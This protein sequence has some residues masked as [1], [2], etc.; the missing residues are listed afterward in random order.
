MKLND[1]IK[2][3]VAVTITAALTFSLTVSINNTNNTTIINNYQ[4][5]TKK[6]EQQDQK[7]NT[8]QKVS[9]DIQGN[10][11]QVES[12][13]NKTLTISKEILRQVD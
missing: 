1:L 11:S 3:A 4:E 12:N 5:I 9:D 2:I 8:I 10:T 7:L 13:I 6:L